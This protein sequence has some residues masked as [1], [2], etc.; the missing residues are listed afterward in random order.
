MSFGN[1][2]LIAEMHADEVDPEL[3]EILVRIEGSLLRRGLACDRYQ[4]IAMDQER[5]ASA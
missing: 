4:P 5:P 1:Q 3:D 2:A